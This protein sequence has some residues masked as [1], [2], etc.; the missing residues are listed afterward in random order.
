WVGHGRQAQCLWLHRDS[1]RSREIAL[2]AED[3]GRER[4]LQAVV[5]YQPEPNLR[6]AREVCYS[7]HGQTQVKVTPMD[8][9][10]LREVVE[11]QVR[12]VKTNRRR[13][14]L[15]SGNF[16]LSQIRA[17]CRISLHKPS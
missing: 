13:S 4:L 7:V 8:E 3:P 6:S 11:V 2:Q 1:C 15:Q 10:F 9:V 16:E 12:K 14:P 17:T 5:P